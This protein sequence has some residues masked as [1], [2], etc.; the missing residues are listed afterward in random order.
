MTQTP[1]MSFGEELRR[2]RLVREISL[3]EIS[4]AT[5]I[6]MRLLTAL[7]AS[8]VDRLPAPTFTR[9]FIRAY[10]A[11]LGLDPDEKVNAY[12][13]DLA[14]GAPDAPSAKRARPRSRFWRG[15]RSTAGTIVGGVT[16]LLLLL[17]WIATV[18]R[19]PA[20][21]P[22]RSAP[23]AAPVAF[24]NVSVASEPGPLVPAPETAANATNEAG[25]A[26]RNDSA[27]V[28]SLVLDFDGDSWTKLEADGETIF[29]GV[30]R[31]GESKRFE[32]RHG[33]RLTL[34]N[35]GAV[36]VTVDGRS[37]ER[38]GAAGEVVRDLA[39]PGNAARG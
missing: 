1:P 34:G 6:S 37:L 9:G 33:F 13:A 21:L 4:S 5:K 30:L 29:S 25:T 2:E 28:V 26:E 23:A 10:S 38:L 36:R 31:R 3:E 16:G 14:G 17:G 7:E 24:K 18:R 35:A 11:H 39:L 8:D 22:E 20:T 19:Q 27:G 12:L 15:R 32:A